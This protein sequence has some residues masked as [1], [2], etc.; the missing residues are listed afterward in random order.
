MKH[1]IPDTPAP[2]AWYFSQDN[3]TGTLT[4]LEPDGRRHVVRRGDWGS[5]AGTALL[6]RMIQAL[7]KTAADLPTPPVTDS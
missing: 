2:G 5:L 4:A 3:Q 1:Q 6:N 7:A